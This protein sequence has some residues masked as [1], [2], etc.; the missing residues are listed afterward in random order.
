M[1][2]LLSSAD[3]CSYS[4]LQ[5]GHPAFPPLTQILPYYIVNWLAGVART[6]RLLY[7]QEG[8]MT[9]EPRNGG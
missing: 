5:E 8:K 4:G 6:A 7:F 2:P 3:T 1:C 9:N